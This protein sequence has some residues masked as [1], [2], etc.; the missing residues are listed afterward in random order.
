MFDHTSVFDSEWLPYNSSYCNELVQSKQ[1]L[2][3][4]STV[5]A[6]D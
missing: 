3:I 5:L 6:M 4:D 2:A 1:P